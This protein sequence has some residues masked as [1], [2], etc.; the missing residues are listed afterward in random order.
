MD[1]RR[2]HKVGTNSLAVTLPRRWAKRIGLN[3]GDAVNFRD[4]EDASLILFRADGCSVAPVRATFTTEPGTSPRELERVLIG[5]YVSAYDTV[6]VFAQSTFTREQ[7][8]ALR[9]TAQRL[10]GFAVVESG[11]AVFRVQ[12][13][14]DPSWSGLSEHVHRLLKVTDDM[15]ALAIPILADRDAHAA[16]EILALGDQTDRLYYLTVRFLTLA[17]NDRAVAHHMGLDSVQE[18]MG[19]RVLAKA[20]EEIGDSMETVADVVLRF[21]DQDIKI[22]DDIRVGLDQFV[23]RICSHMAVGV[24]AFFSG[25]AERASA[26]LESIYEMEH[27]KVHFTESV[28]ARVCDPAGATMLTACAMAL[29]DVCRFTR[30]IGETAMNNALRRRV[31]AAGE[32][33]PGDHPVFD[34]NSMNENGSRVAASSRR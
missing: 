22:A 30:V 32:D 11:P 1:V 33:P 16:R 23:N 2:V 7:L 3:A 19:C 13:Y 28:L 14:L 20:L 27:E 24:D 9:L 34:P 29:R 18:A 6:D 12:S 10:T 25:S 4:E 17:T 5:Y 21:Q 26:L 31:E 8:D 15:V